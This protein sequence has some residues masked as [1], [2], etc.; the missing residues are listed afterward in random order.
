MST[1][2]LTRFFFALG[3]LMIGMGNS[4]SVHAVPIVGL[5]TVGGN[6]NTLVVFDTVSPGSLIYSVPVSGLP[7]GFNLVGIDFRPATGGLT[8]VGQGAGNVGGVFSLNLFTGAATQVNTIPSLTGTAFGVDFNPVPDALRIVSNTGQNLR[9]P[10]GGTGVVTTDNTLSLNG[11]TGAAYS[12]N[13]AGATST[14]LYDIRSTDGSL[15]TQIPPNNGTLN[16]VG[17]LGLGTGLSESVGFDISGASGAAFASIGNNL[18]SINLT[19]G[20]AT[21]AG[22]VSGTVQLR[23]ITF[24]PANAAIPEPGSVLML[25]G[26]LIGGAVVCRRRRKHA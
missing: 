19:T 17:S 13:V 25:G 5:G 23:D 21:S 20:V 3:L 18:Y 6:T 8:A 1:R 12:N 26:L 11:V 24:I 9:I 15:Y 16:L 4:V 10:V 7:S 22:T 2:R 14:T